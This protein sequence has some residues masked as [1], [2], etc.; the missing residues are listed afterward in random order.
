[1]LPGSGDAQASRQ[2]AKGCPEDDKLPEGTKIRGG[3][4]AGEEEACRRRTVGQE[5]EA[6]PPS[7]PSRTRPQVEAVRG[8]EWFEEWRRKNRT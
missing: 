5:L 6:R 2:R 3:T 8:E 4:G 7:V 1:M